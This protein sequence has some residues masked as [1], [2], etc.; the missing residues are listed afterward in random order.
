MET[1]TLSEKPE[2]EFQPGAPV[3]YAMHGKCQVVKTEV[4]LLDGANIRFYK[5]EVKKSSF[6]RSNRQDPAIWVPVIQARDL[7]LR[8]PMTQEEAEVAMKLLNS[9]EYFFD[10]HEPWSVVHSKLENSIRVEGGI[11][12]AKV[13]S[14]LFVLKKKQIVPSSEVLKLQETIQKLLFREMSDA[15]LQPIRV[16]EERVLKGFK[17]KLIPDN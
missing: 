2:S 17:A 7:G 15:L 14:F 3:I 10:P 16:I 5:L 8:S 4:R 1:Q 9:R 11:G 12:L 6:S 13:A